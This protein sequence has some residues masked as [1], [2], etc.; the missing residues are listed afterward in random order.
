MQAMS[1]SRH[2][3]RWIVAWAVAFL[4]VVM[5]VLAGPAAARAKEWRIEAMDVNLDVQT[6]SA[7][8]PATSKE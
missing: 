7:L 6:S 2:P 8:L 4:V 3:S 5:V 1:M